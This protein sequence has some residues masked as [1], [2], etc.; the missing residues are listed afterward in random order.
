MFTSNSLRALWLGCALASLQVL[1]AGSYPG[2]GRTPTPDEVKA[3]DIDVRPDFSGLPPGRGTV[4]RGQEVW[5]AKCASCHGTFGESNEYFTPIIGG[6]TPD[7][8]RT[9]VAK[10]LTTSALQRTTMMKL[11]SLATMWDYIR[12]AMPWTAPKS[13]GD[14]DVY[15]VTAYIL[16]LADLV[17]ANFVL[18]DA[19]IRETE[20]LLPNRNGLT[21]A[22]G[23]WELRGRPD[24]HNSP[25]MKDC[26]PLARVGSSLPGHARNA[27]GNLALQ[28][29]TIGGVVGADTTRAPLA[30][31][32]AREARQTLGVAKSQSHADTPPALANRNGCMACHGV[33][34]KVIGPAFRDVA[35]RYAADK[36]ASAAL[37]AHI[38]A[39][40]GGKW[41]EI[42]M[43]P[44][45]QVTP[46][47]A[48][49]LAQW[50]A[51]GA[52]VP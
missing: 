49:T 30:F 19:N 40:G 48:D 1:A 21:R 51:G 38:R 28:N 3:W 29:R 8:V 14:D 25:C 37:A 13:L 39:G 24:V 18:S 26:G 15:A 35:T 17:P 11:S 20:K 42:P 6:T 46:A 23:L 16:N 44:Q 2:I 5:D 9:G 43:P 52:A 7:D 36:T 47:D 22:H 41:G 4:A 34:R 10:S 32:E 33:E 45:A 50:I 12:R 31:G 27:H